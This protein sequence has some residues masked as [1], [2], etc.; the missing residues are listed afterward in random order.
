M[1]VTYCISDVIRHAASHAVTPCAA[2]KGGFAMCRK[3]WL[4]LHFGDTPHKSPVRTRTS[5]LGVLLSVTT[6]SNPQI[7]Q[8]PSPQ[9][10]VNPPTSPRHSPPRQ[11]T[12]R[13][14]K[15]RCQ[16]MD[17]YRSGHI[18]LLS[19]CSPFLLSSGSDTGSDA[20]CDPERESPGR[21]AGTA[22]D[23]C[24]TSARFV[25]RLSRCDLVFAFSP[26]AKSRSEKFTGHL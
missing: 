19:F 22:G 23:F 20:L 9:L 18:K 25:P 15:Y 16:R 3:L 17:V 5:A 12:L 13:G 6:W 11:T 4:G 7:F 8:L 1:S 24:R 2:A 14:S 21:R 26:H 10:P